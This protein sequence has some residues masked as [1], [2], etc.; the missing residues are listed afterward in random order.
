MDIK[1]FEDRKKQFGGGDY[2]DLM[3][4]EQKR[5]GNYYR[6]QFFQRYAEIRAMHETEWNEH[7]KLYNCKRDPVADDEDYPNSFIP[8]ITPTVEGQVASILETDIDFRHVTNNPAHERFM[9]M[10]DA[11]S[12]F[13]RTK[14]RFKPH[15]KDFARKYDLQGN[16]WITVQWEPGFGKTGYGEPNGCPRLYIPD[17]LSVLV[18]GRIKDPKDVQ[19]ADYIIHIKDWQSIS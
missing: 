15:A 8:I 1:I 10:F 3:T 4:E 6:D 18:D 19:Y 9:P 7:E 17:L 14:A 13:Y 5:R 16:A 11:A 2:T 12:E